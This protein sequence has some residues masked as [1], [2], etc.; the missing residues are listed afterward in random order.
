M[1]PKRGKYDTNPLDEDVAHRAD[2]SFGGNGSG[3]ATED[4]SGSTNPINR[5]AAETSRAVNQN[6][7]PTRRMDEKVTSYPSVFVPPPRT[8]TTYAAPPSSSDII[9]RHRVSRRTFIGL[10]ACR[11][12]PNQGCATSRGLAFRNVGHPCSRICPFPPGS[13]SSSVSLNCF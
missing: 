9:C 8:T 1:V 12:S 5:S 7:T 10:R 13:E 11:C 3:A 4:I 2:D 6:E